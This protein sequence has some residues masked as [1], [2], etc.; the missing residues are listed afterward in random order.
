MAEILPSALMWLLAVV[1]VVVN[2]VDQAKMVDVEEVD[3]AVRAEQEALVLTVR[4]ATAEVL[5][6]VT[7]VLQVVEHVRLVEMANI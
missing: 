5:M 1:V 6:S 4:D 3:G 7:K 2:Q